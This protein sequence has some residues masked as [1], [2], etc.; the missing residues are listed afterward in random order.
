M[1]AHNEFGSVLLR[2]R[3]SY[4]SYIAATNALLD[5]EQ[6]AKVGPWL[7]AASGELTKRLHWVNQG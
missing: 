7:E 6:R 1:A 4:D 2:I 5:D 3:A